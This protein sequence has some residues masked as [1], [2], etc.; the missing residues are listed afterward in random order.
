MVFED[1]P[2]G[3]QSALTA[4]MKCVWVPDSNVNKS[5]WE[6]KLKGVD[7]ILNSLEEFVPEEFGLPP[8]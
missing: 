7:L 8:Y 3:V 1:A 4:G 5:D 6:V 2:N